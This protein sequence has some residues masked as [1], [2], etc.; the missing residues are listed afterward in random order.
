MAH[1]RL[2]TEDRRRAPPRST[3]LRA[4]RSGGAEELADLR[5]VLVGPEQERIT[6]VEQASTPQS[7]GA[8]LPEAVAH[9][10]ANREDDLQTALSQPVKGAVADVARREPTLFAEILAP[11]VG[12][13][14]R[15]AVA[16]A[17]STILE[18]LNQLLERGLSFRSVQWRIE[19]LR[20]RRPVAEV[21]L[22]RTLIYRVEWIVLVK[23]DSSLVLEQAS[24][25]DVVSRAPDQIAAM[26]QAI[27]AF[28]SE[29]FQ[30]AA[31]GG[32]LHTFEVGDLTVWVERQGAL[33]IAAA[34]RGNAPVELRGELRKTLDR[35]TTLHEEP[36]LDGADFGDT[37]PLLAECLHQTFKTSPNRA[38]WILGAFGIMVALLCAGLWYRVHIANIREAE[39]ARRDAELRAAY[40][41]ALSPIP[42]VVVL[43]IDRSGDQYRIN[44]LRDPRS[45]PVDQVIA[46]AGLPPVVLE[47]APYDSLDPRF[48][49]EKA[50]VATHVPKEE[51][52]RTAGVVIRALEAIEI[53][54]D[55][56]ATKVDSAASE[57]DR[58]ANLTKEVDQAAQRGGARLCLEIIGETDEK[59]SAIANQ[60]LRKERASSVANA[61][62]DRGVA[63]ELLRPRAAEPAAS[64]ERL[65][66]FRA[67]IHLDSNRPGCR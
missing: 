60:R 42:G 66:R 5:Q 36:A 14:V 20:T 59:G 65:V 13:A 33:T 9:A 55:P 25:P 39:V 7:L 41:N 27:G 18:R 63:K 22:S 12:T 11:L 2:H 46:T 56:G 30:P 64:R 4:H 51:P 61:L 34:I 17:I 54:F 21:I 58:V 57:L 10:V 62:R 26:L 53:D 23:T 40:Q 16:D 3:L 38:P 6:R 19:A 32:E 48:Q 44:G 31:P 28:V 43:S 50:P 1:G 52:L 15:K 37:Y 45:E 67:T 35:V 47:L 24:L 8:L 49:E 29:A